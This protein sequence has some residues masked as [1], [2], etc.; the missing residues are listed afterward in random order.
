MR[1]KRGASKIGC[2]L[3]MFI[4]SVCHNQFFS[5]FFTR[6]NSSL[7]EENQYFPREV[8]AINNSVLVPVPSI[9]ISTILK[10]WIDINRVV[11]FTQ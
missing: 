3:T 5:S 1:R 4:Q 10:F 11:F 7:G 9:S 6:K 2:K 8:F